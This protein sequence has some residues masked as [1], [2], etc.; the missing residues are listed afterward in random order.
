LDFIKY[1]YQFSSSSPLT[2]IH[3]I[4]GTLLF[5]T[6]LQLRFEFGIGPLIFHYVMASG[7]R[8]ISQI[9]RFL[10]IFSPLPALPCRI[11]TNQNIV[12]LCW[13]IFDWIIS[14]DFVFLAIHSKCFLWRSWCKLCKQEQIS[15][16]VYIWKNSEW[17]ISHGILHLAITFRLFIRN[18]ITKNGNFKETCAGTLRHVMEIFPR[19]KSAKQYD[20]IVKICI[21]Q[22]IHFSP[23]KCFHATFSCI[24]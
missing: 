4:S 17:C 23:H 14:R 6:I 10:H 22:S 12:L 16:L 19:I 21:S 18:T 3:L 20:V 8:K 9:I 2:Y 5:R 24:E 7:L 11:V 13:I 15:S 1:H